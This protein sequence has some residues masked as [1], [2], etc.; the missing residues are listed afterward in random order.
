MNATPPPLAKLYHVVA[1]H[2]PPVLNSTTVR[3]L[4]I[5]LSNSDVVTSKLGAL[6]EHH[7]NSKFRTQT[8]KN[9]ATPVLVRQLHIG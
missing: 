3:H 9:S 1:D 8:Q 6:L 7:K 4:S 2:T 5:H